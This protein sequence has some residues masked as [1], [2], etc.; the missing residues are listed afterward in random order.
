MLKILFAAATL[1]LVAAPAMALPCK[2][3]KG[4]FM[5]CAEVKKPAPTKCRKGGKFA[6]CGTPG[7]KPF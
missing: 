6:K 4:R 7:A 5:K 3:A 2:D 1:S